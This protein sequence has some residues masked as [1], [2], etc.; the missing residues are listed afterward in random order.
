[1]LDYNADQWLCQE[2][3]FE[4]VTSAAR[5]L[6]V[7]KA[8]KGSGQ[9]HA[10]DFETTSLRPEDGDIRITSIFG[11]TGFFVIDH[12]AACPFETIADEIASLTFAVCNAGFEGRWIDFYA[13]TLVDLID[14]GLMRKAKMGGG[15]VLGLKDIA[16]RDVGITVDKTEQNS[17]WG[18]KVLTKEQ[19]KYAGFDA[20]V[21]YAIYDR[22]VNELTPQQ[23][24]GFRVIN[25]CWRA[26]AEAEDTGLLLDCQYHAGLVAFWQRKFDVSERYL[27]KWAPP[28]L[29]ANLQSTMQVGK[30]IKE[31]MIDE[32]SYRSWPKTGKRQQMDTSRETLRQAAHRLPY[33]MSRW[34]AALIIFNKSRKY[35]STYG[36][37]LIDAQNKYGRVKSRFNIAAAI[38]GR[39][40]SSSENLQNMPRS[41]VVRRS[42]VADTNFPTG[43][44]G[45]R[46][47]LVIADYSSIEVRV[48]AEI[49][50]DSELLA[51]A[52]YGNIHATSAADMLHMDRGEFLRILK[53]DTDYRQAK[54]KSLR[55]AAKATTFSVCIAEGS[56]VLTPRGL[57]P[58]EAVTVDDLVWDGVEWVSHTGVIYQGEKEVISVDGL[59]A[60]VDHKVWLENG[61]TTRLDQVGTRRIAR[62]GE[63][64]KAIRFVADTFCGSMAVPEPIPLCFDRLCALRPATTPSAGVAVGDGHKRTVC[65]VYDITNAGPRRRFTVSGRLVSNCYGAGI[66]SLA[67]SLKVTDEKAADA[68]AAWGRR[69]PKA[70]G[71][72]QYMFEKLMATG[73]IEVADGRT[74]FVF[75][76]ERTLPVASNYG[77]QGAA[78]SVMCRAMFHVHRLLDAAGIPAR[79]AATVHDEIVLRAR[80]GYEEQTK[81]LLEE[82]MRLGWLDIFPGSNTDNLAE[83]A[84]GP[85]W[86]A[87]A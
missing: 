57:V 39:Y 41:K 20:L 53:D 23:W 26:T 21:T 45:A 34:M 48:L 14:V 81:A 6:A 73:F 70:F 17:A 47:A 87:K 46:Y 32:T 80:K 9:V 55:S 85:H 49:A 25:D 51:E 10:L 5:A 24:G 52:V 13:T 86:G 40:S 42:F 37:K 56:P 18:N 74:V 69:Y 67:V 66:A 44:E 58:I 36:N 77:I 22:W 63:G 27:R 31:H 7:V 19:Y 38:T 75:K 78:A 65:R 43:G 28:S 64:R 72:R 8:V 76:A 11:P 2:E 15:P 83:A 59:T 12:F 68:M 4:I 61:R 54:F 1:M 33:P 71:Y 60:T 84:I 62:T 35:L 29:I 50:Q 82:G 79:I 16:L 3:K 30:F